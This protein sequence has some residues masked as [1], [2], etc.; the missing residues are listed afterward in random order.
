MESVT[1]ARRSRST[2][3]T[4]STLQRLQRERQRITQQL[5]RIDHELLVLVGTRRHGGSR[6]TR[7]TH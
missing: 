3:S 7:A 1:H 6:R 2:Q 5:A 4:S